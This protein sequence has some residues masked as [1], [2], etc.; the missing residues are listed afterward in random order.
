MHPGAVSLRVSSVLRSAEAYLDARC[1]WAS[2]HYRVFNW[3]RRFATEERSN[4]RV[5]IPVA[6]K[7]LIQL[8]E[9]CR[10]SLRRGHANLL[11]IYILFIDGTARRR[12][13]SS[14]W[15]VKPEAK[16]LFRHCC[17]PIHNYRVFLLLKKTSHTLTPFHP[18]QLSGCGVAGTF[19]QTIGFWVYF[20]KSRQL[21]GVPGRSPSPVLTWPCIA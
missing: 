2:S 18:T 20:M 3:L 16:I 11:C 17:G 19:L 13:T 5:L 21:R 12:A 1:N 10:S 4:Y 6:A 14:M 9:L 8:P 15:G 7:N